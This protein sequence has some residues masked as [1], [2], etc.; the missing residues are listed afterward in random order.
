MSTESVYSLGRCGAVGDVV[1]VGDGQSDLLGSVE[2]LIEAFPLEHPFRIGAGTYEDLAKAEIVVVAVGVRYS[3][4]K[5]FPDRLTANAQSVRLA[6]EHLR[7]IGFDGIVLVMTNPADEMTQV[8]QQAIGLPAER[9]IGIG[10][11]SPWVEPA[12]RNERKKDQ[13]AVTWCSAHHSGG[14]LMDSCQ[15][16]CPYFESILKEFRE[17]KMSTG[18]PGTIGANSLASCTMPRL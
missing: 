18:E 3:T 5:K 12:A 16:D 8:A 4:F 13:A 1:L 17:S 11:I 15:P 6:M 9:V 10:G 2:K 7:A 14:Q